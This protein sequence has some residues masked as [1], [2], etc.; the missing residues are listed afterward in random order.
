MKTKKDNFTSGKNLPWHF[1]NEDG[2]NPLRIPPINCFY[3]KLA[4]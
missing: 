3:Y 2:F 4:E 1:Y